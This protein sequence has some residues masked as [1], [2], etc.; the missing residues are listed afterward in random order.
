MRQHV[1]WAKAAGIDGFLVSWKSTPALD[2]RLARLIQVA[3]AEH[4]HLGIVYEGLDFHRRPLP[5]ATVRHDLERFAATFARDRGVHDL[6]PPGRGLERHLALHERPDPQRD[7]GSARTPARA[8]LGQE[9]RRL[10]ARRA[11][12][13]RRRLLLVVREPAALHGLRAQAPRALGR[14]ARPSR[15]L[16][17]TRRA[18]LRLAPGRRHEHRGASRRRHA[19]ARAQYGRRPP[20]R[21]RSA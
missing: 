1:R 17:R 8:R 12:R 10:R 7:A 21:M 13:R 4:F 16:D 15:P 20:R 14:G 6:R 19:A 2:E 18:G 9:R 3:D 5:I 11:A